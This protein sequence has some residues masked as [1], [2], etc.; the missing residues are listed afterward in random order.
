MLERLK[1][2]W[3]EQDAPILEALQPGLSDARMDELVAPLGISLPDEAREWWGWHNGVPGAAGRIKRRMTAIFEFLSLE[4]AVTECLE[5]REIARSG[6]DQVAP[7]IFRPT[8]LPLAVTMSSPVAVCETAG[9]PHQPAPVYLL[10]WGGYE[11]SHRVP[12]AD[13]ITEMVGYWLKGYEAGLYTYLPDK[14]RWYFDFDRERG[15][16]PGVRLL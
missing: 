9:D 7:G 12:A 6:G 11:S 14:G 15:L 3:R 16:L 8:W 13:S 2:R 5:L 10:D 1:E 4:D